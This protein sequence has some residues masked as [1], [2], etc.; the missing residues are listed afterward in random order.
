MMACD[1]GCGKLPVVELL[2]KKNYSQYNIVGYTTV[3]E[4]L[5]N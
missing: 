5:K 1:R 2:A 3:D 4:Y